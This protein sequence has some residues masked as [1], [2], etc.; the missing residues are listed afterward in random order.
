MKR[1]SALL[2]CLL[3]LSCA[4]AQMDDVREKVRAEYLSAA[5]K[6]DAEKWKKS[7]GKDGRWPDIDY[8]DGSR[9]LW[10]L[11]YHLDRIVDMA[12]AY[13]QA[14]KKDRQMLDKAV[15]A[16][17][18]WFDTGYRND[19][20]WYQKIGVPRRMLSLAYILD[21][22]IPAELRQKISRSLDIIDSED[23]PARPG[24]DRIQVISNHAKVLIW[25]HDYAE[26]A[27]LFKKIEAEARIAPLEEIM[28]DAAGGPAVRN[29][30]HPAG[31]GVQAD[32]TFH[33]RG[34]RVNSTLTYGME[35][36]EYYSY[37]AALLADTECRFAPEGINF[38][39]DYY[40]DAVCRHL[41]RGRYA[42]PSIMN[43]ELSR[44]GEGAVTSRLVKRL[45]AVSGGYRLNEL[46]NAADIFDGNAEFS[47]S[48]AHHFWQ[49]D[50]FVFGRPTF[51][52]AVRIHSVRNANQEAAHN[53]EGLRNH[54]RGDGACMLSVTGREYAD[55]WPLYDF[56]KIPGATTPLLPYG[57]PD[58]WGPLQVLDD[59][60]VFAGAVCD[61]L[62]GA[63]GFDFISGQ[64]GLKARKGWFFFDE[65]YVCLGSDIR[66]DIP[67]SIVTTV[68]QCYAA[69]PVRR[70]G[71]RVFHAGNC[72][73]IIDGDFDASTA[74]RHG[75]WRNCVD[76]VDYADNTSEGDIFSLT[77]MHGIKP[78]N[79]TYAYSVAPGCG[80]KAPEQWFKIIANGNGLQAVESND[81]AVAYM[82]FYEKGEITTSAGRFAVDR[83]CMLMLR[84]GHLYLA[85]P[86]RRHH[87]VTV[88]TPRGKHEV[89]LPTNLRAG[90]TV[91]VPYSCIGR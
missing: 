72:Y 81:G 18:H 20:W 5:P 47:G 64:T 35:L 90:T 37:W 28:L 63:V 46:Q 13:E 45:A 79:G 22:D 10:Q 44:P 23:H 83:P 86:S 62:Y 80:D 3:A 76:K 55:I 41:V 85:D 1:L 56:R 60:T 89:L 9:S 12:L 75:S 24:G 21:S 66:S 15:L 17:K 26:A 6:G 70:D 7:L 67:D 54:F 57:Q 78:T 51:Q 59:P 74:H 43:R 61:S 11:E 48:Y 31:R 25:R 68:E 87:L 49:S 14:P 88:T 71:S 2:I 29:S 33:H 40:L 58:D 8:T 42:E 73:H 53:S 27:K 77:L 82:I 36:P 19:N 30:W 91:E 4:L 65:G 39:I 32:M 52:T 84:Q 69:T 50:Y 38:V 16:L 34:D